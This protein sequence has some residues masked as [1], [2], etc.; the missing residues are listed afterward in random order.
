M[1]IQTAIKPHINAIAWG[2]LII[3]F[4][5]WMT[6]VGEWVNRLHFLGKTQKTT[7]YVIE[8]DEYDFPGEHGELYF[9]HY[10]K[11]TYTTQHGFTFTNVIS[12]S[13]RIESYYGDIEHGDPLPVEYS[14]YDSSISRMVNS[15]RYDDL[16]L[17]LIRLITLWYIGCYLIKSGIKDHITLRS[18]LLGHIDHRVLRNE[19]FHSIGLWLAK[20]LVIILSVLCMGY[21]LSVLGPAIFAK[22]TGFVS[23]VSDKW[24]HRGILLL[25]SILII[26]IAR[27][28]GADKEVLEFIKD[29][30]H[31]FREYILIRREV[32][33]F[34]KQ[35]K[36]RLNPDK[37]QSHKSADRRAP[38]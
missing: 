23:N 8:T 11:Y 17:S 27:I 13:G 22:V 25:W 16:L 2:I 12:G 5:I 37:S 10:V 9:R 32:K 6:D 18:T 33:A 35:M 19:I 31:R 1:N 38:H 28:S 3:I 15:S 36:I 21:L 7:G 29:V 26:F 30:I 20:A 14:K 4:A 34:E 24:G